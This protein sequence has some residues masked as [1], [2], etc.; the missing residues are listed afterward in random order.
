LGWDSA[1]K[2]QHLR[3]VV[4]N[5]R[6][7]ILPWIR[8]ANLASQILGVNMRRLSADWQQRYGHAL[9][10][11]ETFV[12]SARFYGGCYRASNWRYVGETSGWSKRGVDYTFHGRKKS[13]FVIALVRRAEKRLCLSPAL[14][15]EEGAMSPDRTRS[16]KIPLDIG[17]FDLSADEG[18]FAT[19]RSVTDDRDALGKRYSIE[20]ILAMALCAALAEWARDQS[21]KDLERLGSK[22]G[23]APNE[24]TF[25]RVLQRANVEEI[26]TK[27]GVWLAKQLRIQP[28]QA[29]ALDGKSL[30]GSRDGEKKALH[31]L[32]AIVHDSG[33]VI[34]QTPVADK[35]NEITRV[36]PPLRP[37]DLKGCVVTADALHTQQATA[38][39]VVEDKQ[40][41]YLLTVKENQP[42][43]HDDIEQLHMEAFPPS[44]RDR[45]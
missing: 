34:A 38:R 29:L 19:L 41:D 6:F 25:R 14:T 43:L 22:Y 35:T 9:W 16:S 23:K 42:T 12:D 32:S 10:F 33:V 45:R 26:D 24:I 17:A 39:H 15:T 1:S 28:G 44:G 37:L 3:Y 13:V 20:S 21:R 40:A 36:E 4:N 18:L 8:Q 7:L 11:A 30:R 31:L 2:T 27:T 5:A